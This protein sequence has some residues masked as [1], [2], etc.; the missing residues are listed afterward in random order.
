MQKRYFEIFAFKMFYPLFVT[1]AIV[2]L[3]CTVER[4]LII[5]MQWNQC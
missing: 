5:A 4:V 2:V 1:Q 3:K